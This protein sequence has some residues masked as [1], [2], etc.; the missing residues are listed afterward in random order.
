MKIINKRNK[1]ECLNVKDI[2]SLTIFKKLL[3]KEVLK[4]KDLFNL[5]ELFSSMIEYCSSVEKNKF[6][7]IVV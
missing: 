7:K 6:T 3:E 2:D 5:K 4:E 1:V